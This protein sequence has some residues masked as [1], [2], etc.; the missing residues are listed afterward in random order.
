MK[1]K[2]KNIPKELR[3]HYRKMIWQ[4]LKRAIWANFN[5]S[6]LYE[7]RHEIFA[8]GRVEDNIDLPLD[9]LYW[10]CDNTETYGGLSTTAVIIIFIYLLKYIIV[11]I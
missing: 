4:S 10:Y 1:N 2:Y 8:L 9:H 5:F 11:F 3:R 7:K 6:K